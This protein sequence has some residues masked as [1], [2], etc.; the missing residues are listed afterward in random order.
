MF[1]PGA[2]RPGALIRPREAG[3]P[4]RVHGGVLTA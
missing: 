2:L 4:G 1:R 3:D